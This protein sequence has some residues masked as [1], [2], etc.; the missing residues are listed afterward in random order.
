M[1][2]YVGCKIDKDKNSRE[3]KIT[4]PA[5]L[6]S[7]KDE[8]NIENK[9]TS[10]PVE[11]GTVLVKNEEGNKVNAKEHTY[12]RSG[13]GKLLHMAR[14]RRHDIQNSVRELARQGSCP[15]KAHIKAMHRAIDY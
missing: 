8:Y 6:Q 4:Q 5:L 3:I 11:V 7:Y 9:K 15:T 14:W 2:E 1:K 12:Y 13:V 10:N